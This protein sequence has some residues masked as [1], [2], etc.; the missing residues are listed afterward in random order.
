LISTLIINDILKSENVIVAEASKPIGR[1]YFPHEESSS[2]ALFDI[3]D[4][5]KKLNG[6]LFHLGR[7]TKVAHNSKEKVI[8][9]IR[10]S[11]LYV[12]IYLRVQFYII[13]D[14]EEPVMLYLSK[15]HERDLKSAIL[16]AAVTPVLDEVRLVRLHG[17]LSIKASEDLTLNMFLSR[18]FR[19][20]IIEKSIFTMYEA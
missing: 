6:N 10:D 12:S 8:D 1:D 7:C 14:L 5:I 20:R 16:V 3:F 13:G 19:F 18:H 9:L 2:V 17:K 4:K 11:T 15:N